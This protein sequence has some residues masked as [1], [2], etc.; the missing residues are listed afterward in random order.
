M[1][2]MIKI[3]KV[4][5]FLPNKKRWSELLGLGDY[6]FEGGCE[7]YKDIWDLFCKIRHILRK[8]KSSHFD[9]PIHGGRQYKAGFLK[10]STDRLGQSSFN[11]N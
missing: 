5:K 1:M 2:R 8:K 11:D 4:A 7:S 3:Q 6:L 9:T 10:E